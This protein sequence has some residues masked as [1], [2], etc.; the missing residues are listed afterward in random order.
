MIRLRPAVLSLFLRP[1]PD[2]WTCPIRGDE[3]R[4]RVLGAPSTLVYSVIPGAS[5]DHAQ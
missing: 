2:R 3:G 1:G 4:Q 5:S